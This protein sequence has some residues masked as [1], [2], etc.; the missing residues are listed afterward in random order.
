MVLAVTLVAGYLIVTEYVGGQPEYETYLPDWQELE[1]YSLNEESG[2]SPVT[3]LE[4]FD[5]QC[6]HC[7]NLHQKL[8][9][10]KQDYSKH[11]AVKA[12]PYPLNQQG[13][14]YEA[15][16]TSICTNLQSD[17]TDAVH[18]SLFELQEDFEEIETDHIITSAVSD[19]DEQSVRNCLQNG[20][21]ETYLQKNIKA[22]EQ[23]SLTRVPA[24]IINGELYFGALPDRRLSSIIEAHL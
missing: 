18:S 4:F 13:S 15:A 5:Y 20:E 7:K 12:I 24:L 11:L 9:R 22:G 2:N 1:Y 19:H 17:E 6:S 3:I 10:I 8:N 23:L 21:Y 14:G 16:A